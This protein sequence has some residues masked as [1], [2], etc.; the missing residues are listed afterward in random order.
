MV[1]AERFEE[2]ARSFH[3]TWDRLNPVRASWLGIHD[4]DDRLGDYS[5]AG[6]EERSGDLLEYETR[7]GQ[8]DPSTLPPDEQ[9]DYALVLAEIRAERWSVEKVADWRR[10]PALYVQTP[11]M[12]LLSLVTRDHAP[13]PE[14]IRSAIGRLT[15]L[16]DVLEAGRENVENPP[17]Q[18]TEV[19]MQATQ[20]GTTF[21]R[22]VLPSLARREP[23]LEDE[24]LESLDDAEVSL[25][26]HMHYLRA[27]LL[28][29]S[30]GEFSIGREL[31]DERLREWHL[32][33][34]DAE[35]LRAVGERLLAESRAEI[36]RLAHDIDESSDWPTLVE[37]AKRDHPAAGELLGAYRQEMDRLKQFIRE[38]DLVE[39][40]SGESLEVVETPSFQRSVV[41]YAAYMPPGPFDVDQN[42]QFWVTPV[43]REAS[44]REQA[45][46]LQEHCIYGVPITSLHEAYP[47]HHL[48]F[49]W[50]N[51]SGT[52]VR[53]RA[54]SDLFCEGWAFYCEQLFS[55]QGYYTDP[56]TRLFQLKDQLWRSARV[57]IDASLHSGEMTF[58]DAVKFL[59]DQA[60]LAEAQAR[61]EVRRYIMT[62]SQ[63]MTYAIGKE[64]ILRLRDEHKSLS[65]RQF[66][67]KL[68]GVGTIPLALARRV[69]AH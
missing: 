29:A 34:L 25:D 46:Q 28:P 37:K 21:I 59:V 39:I 36:E 15:E 69:F 42:G 32:L 11:L 33:D 1:Q 7:L 62:P 48:Q 53:R 5:E 52:A 35:G 9:I 65:L 26:D 18:F 66:H 6:F 60:K 50:A 3:E 12:G 67:D 54:Q 40:P 55:E 45:T 8:I 51:R 64:E 10:N 31:F 30:N 47:G 41:P 17:R 44:P 14:R 49:S 68:M 23:D 16:R 57:V 22:Q 63:P 24:L 56:R 19:A 2:L 4:Y 27:E 20:A 43:N 13:L 61:A 58:E 38:H